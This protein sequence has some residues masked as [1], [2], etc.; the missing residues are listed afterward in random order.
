[1]RRTNPISPQIAAAIA[2]RRKHHGL[3]QNAVALEVALSEATISKIETARVPCP[4]EMVVLI[5][6]AIERLG[7][8][9]AQS[10]S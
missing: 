10:A 2:A 1:M 9:K 8:E 5:E 6:R 7:D 4:P 3:T